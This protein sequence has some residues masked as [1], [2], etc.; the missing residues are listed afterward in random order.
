MQDLA[1]AEVARTRTNGDG[2]FSL[3]VPAGDYLVVGLAAEGLMGVPEPQQVTVTDGQVT[4][5]DL[6]YDTGIRGPSRG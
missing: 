3:A 5:V 4:A 6:A 1:G 2:T